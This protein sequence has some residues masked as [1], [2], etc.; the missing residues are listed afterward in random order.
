[1]QAP[2]HI[3]PYVRE[4]IVDITTR[5]VLPTLNLGPINVVG[6]IKEGAAEFIIHEEKK[7]AREV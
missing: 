2:A 4:L 5:S 6:M 1:V 7:D 3:I